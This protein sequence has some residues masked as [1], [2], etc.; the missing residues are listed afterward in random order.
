MNEQKIIDFSDLPKSLRHG[1]YG[2]QAGDKDCVIFTLY[3]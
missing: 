2:G 3:R 1:R